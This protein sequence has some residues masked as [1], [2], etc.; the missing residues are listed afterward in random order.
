[1]NNVVDLL[2]SP[3]IY[4]HTPIIQ[5]KIKKHQLKLIDKNRNVYEVNVKK[6]RT[7]LNNNYGIFLPVGLVQLNGTDTTILMANKNIITFS[8]TFERIAPDVWI[9][10]TTD[11]KQSL[12]TFPYCPK[13]MQVP[14]FSADSLIRVDKHEKEYNIYSDNA[15]GHWI[16]DKAKFFTRINDSTCTTNMCTFYSVQGEVTNENIIDSKFSVYPF[17]DDPISPVSNNIEAAMQEYRG[18]MFLEENEHPWYAKIKTVPFSKKRE[19]FAIHESYNDK[20]IMSMLVLIIILL[21][22]KF[23]LKH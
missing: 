8:N 3:H 13:N 11:G 19:H 15:Y 18:K 16:L 14:V 21:V 4:H 23:S 20:I 7:V 2:G 1:M 12:G 17:D 22:Y 5:I 9:G 6:L 10:K